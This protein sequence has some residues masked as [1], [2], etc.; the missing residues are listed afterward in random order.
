M[1]FRYNI[2]IRFF[3]KKKTIDTPIIFTPIPVKKTGQYS[4]FIN[5]RL[6]TYYKNTNVKSN[7]FIPIH[8]KKYL[9]PIHSNK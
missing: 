3:S 2:G 6:S 7:L 9:H 5:Y 4:M 8:V 1:N